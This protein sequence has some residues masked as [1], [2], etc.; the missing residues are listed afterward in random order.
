M[1]ITPVARP[2]GLGSGSGNAG[3]NRPEPRPLTARASVSHA[4]PPE[5][6]CYTCDTTTEYLDNVTPV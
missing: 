1:C 6:W 3:R 4:L 5:R 2:A